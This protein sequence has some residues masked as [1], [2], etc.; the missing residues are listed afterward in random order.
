MR[1]FKKSLVSSI[2][3]LAILAGCGGGGSHSG[4]VPNGGSVQQNPVTSTPQSGMFK[5]GQQLFSQMSYVGP[6][7]GGNLA[8][9][10]YVQMS[11][12]QGLIQYAADVNNPKSAL[13][14]QWLTPQEIGD[15]FGATQS[16]Y[17]AA[18]KYFAGYG[19]KVGAWPQR[20]ALSVRGSVSQFQRAFGTTFGIYKF[21]GQNVVG[22]RGAPHFSSNVPVAGTSPLMSGTLERPFFIHGNNANFFGYSPQQVATGFDYSG[23]YAAHFNGSGINVGIIGTGPILNSDGKDD[24]ITAYGQ[25]WHAPMAPVAEV[26]V[27]PQPASTP[28]GQTGTGA[29]DPN[30][31]ALATPPP[32]TNPC[33][34]QGDYA[35]CNPEDGEAQL[36]TES[37][38]SLAP[39]SNVRFY[40]AYNPAECEDQ[41]GNV[42]SA[43]SNGS[44][45]SGQFY[46]GAEG[47]QLV[48]DEYQQ[49]IADNRS[50]IISMSFGAPENAAAAGDYIDATG[51]GFGQIEM[52]SF[53]AE[54]VALF[55][56]SGDNGAWECYDTMTGLPN[57]Q[58]CVNYP[59]AD[60]N[61]VGVGGVN[62]P[63]D[64]NG[65]LTGEIAAWGDNTTLGGNPAAV[66]SVG[67]GGGIS[68]VIPAP[69]WQASTLATT[70]REVPD[71]SLDADPYTGQSI[72][73]YA[74]L[75]GAEFPAGGTSMA[76][77]EAAAQWALVL[78]ACRA[79]STCN[80]AGATG[81]RLGNPAPL[82]YAIYGTSTLAKATYTAGTFK[83]GL[84][85]AHVFDDVTYGGNQAVPATP[86]PG[87]AT[88][89]P[90]TGYE[91][92][93]GYDEVTGLGAPFTGHL[94]QAITGTKLP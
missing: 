53:A 86:G 64:E 35:T 50:D 61:V 21:R 54:G 13:Y 5:W 73:E 62:I 38:S 30:P 75:G 65:N 31:G 23:A 25:Y 81:Y 63:L 9:T 2:A 67:S 42:I 8:V 71:M 39:G 17:Q 79:S 10:V 3:G 49:A 27:A 89:P 1:S 94:I 46:A 34:W 43:P 84:D 29:T 18:E 22:L 16:N 69:A 20:E 55:A 28:N 7:T 88:A 87:Q 57:G 93:P 36:D 47:I 4:I 56:S 12:P 44:C 19:L 83:P 33:T 92:G 32:I 76:A 15:K 80:K 37:I 59:A 68:T 40:L 52:A 41:Y 24:D 45:P 66:N 77:P 14:R 90:T 48:D 11:N 82:L 78:Q 85:Y 51:D 60:T 91:S 58:P 74:S 72:L 70:K 26:A 6:A